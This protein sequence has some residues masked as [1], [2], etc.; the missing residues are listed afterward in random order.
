MCKYGSRFFVGYK[1]LAICKKLERRRDREMTG[2]TE[3]H[4]SNNYHT[5]RRSNKT[6]RYKHCYCFYAKPGSFVS[7]LDNFW[8]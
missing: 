4:I 6:D 7:N 1:S 8:H 3:L 5:T 2:Q